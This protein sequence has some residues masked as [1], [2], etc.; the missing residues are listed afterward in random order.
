MGSALVFQSNQRKKFM[1]LSTIPASIQILGR[2]ILASAL[3][4]TCVNAADTSPETPASNPTT[5]GSG[6]ARL[7]G[8]SETEPATSKPYE[9]G[10]RSTQ[11]LTAQAF[12]KAAA[13]GNAAEIALADVAERKAQNPEVKQLATL[14]RKDHQQAAEQLQPV[15]QA[16]GVVTSQTLDA[17]HQ[18]IVDRFQQMSAV[19]FDQEYTKDM[20]KDHVKDIS[21]YEK[22]AQQIKE[23]DV[24]QYAQNT[25]PTLRQ[26]LQHA[27]QAA[28]AAGVDQAT[29][30]SILRKSS[31]SM[32]GTSDEQEEQSGSSQPETE[33]HPPQGPASIP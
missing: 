33:I 7:S 29:I 24:Q 2:G 6:A 1:K 10:D 20:L 28:L 25:L 23:T 8:N 18:K 17:K 5:Q 3:L 22:A 21:K 27:Q 13:E 11:P 15:A 30:S 4:T 32:G 31:D 14:I 9:H 19:K 12:L 26:H 16:H